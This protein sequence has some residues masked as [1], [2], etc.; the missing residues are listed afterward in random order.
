MSA[1][2][3]LTVAILGFGEVGRAFAGALRNA[4]VSVVVHKR[5]T[6]QG[7]SE[8]L[9]FTSSLVDAV[10]RGDLVLSVVTGASA[11]VVAAESVGAMRAGAL[12]VD[13]TATSP[14]TIRE[15]AALFA[16]ASRDYVDAAI[17]GAVGIHGAA[18]P[19]VAA[20]AA[21]ERVAW[22]LNPMGFRFKTLSER[23]GDASA[24]KMLRSLYTKGLEAVIMETMLSAASMGLTDT[25]LDNLGDFDSSSTVQII[26]M[27]LRTHP[28]AAERRLHEM[29]DAT[30][31]LAEIG[32]TSFVM[33]AIL[34]RLKRTLTLRDSHPLPESGRGDPMA[35]LAWLVEAE[36]DNGLRSPA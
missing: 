5:R 25:L 19:V 10:T 2:G 13:L 22:L 4:G 26:E 16:R 35:M 8:G 6:P 17:M 20:G 12:Y 29:S 28:T 18:T 11:M 3:P 27:F 33:P 34:A 24:L 30:Q 31:L 32:L 1:L 15:S 9:D 21:A 23:A 7:S 14:E 36:R